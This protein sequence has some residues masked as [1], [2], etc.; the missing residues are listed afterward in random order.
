MNF[1]NEANKE[2]IFQCGFVYVGH[3]V[4][5]DGILSLANQLLKQMMKQLRDKY[6]CQ[7]GREYSL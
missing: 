3:M 2:G 6:F 1:E 5:K 4:V 7:Y